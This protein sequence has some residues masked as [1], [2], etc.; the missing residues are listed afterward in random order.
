VLALGAVPVVLS[1][2]L[3]GLYAPLPVVTVNAWSELAGDDA[4]LGAKLAGWRSAILARFGDA[5]D[6]HADV[7]QQLSLDWWAQRIR[8]THA[9]DAATAEAAEAREARRARVRVA[10]E[11]VA[12]KLEAGEPAAQ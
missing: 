8:Q 12:N 2:S 4:A 6:E 9:Q 3:D 10:R 5:P 1:S 11:S 7:T